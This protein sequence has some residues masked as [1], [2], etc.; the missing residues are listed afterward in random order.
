MSL[1]KP[2]VIPPGIGPGTVRLLAQL[3]NHY[4]NPGPK[5]MSVTVIKLADLRCLGTQTNITIVC[6]THSPNL[7]KSV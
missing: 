5:T 3:L 7:N 2:T 4:A 1:K 6:V